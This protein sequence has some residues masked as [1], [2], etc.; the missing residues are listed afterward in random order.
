M[1]TRTRPLGMGV[2]VKY[3][4]GALAIGALLV[5]G[6]TKAEALALTPADTTCTTNTNSNLSSAALYAQL[7]TCFDVTALTLN[8]IY[9]DNVET[10]E[11]AGYTFN[12]SYE[13]TYANTATDPADALIE[14]ISGAVFN[15][16]ECYLVV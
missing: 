14:Y 5:G 2:T 3:T 6:T 4:I 15:C 7:E 12:S 9:K 13:T 1:V 8:P 10:G 16:L 11:E